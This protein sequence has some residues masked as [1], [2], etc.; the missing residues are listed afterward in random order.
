MS[1]RLPTALWVDAHL[2]AMTKNAT[3]FYFVQKGNQASGLVLLKINGLKGHVKLLAQERD[4]IEDTLKWVNALDDEIVDE[5]Q[6][7]QYIQRAIERDPDLWVLEIE[8]EALNNPF[9]D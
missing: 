9:T 2:A 5:K 3:P 7:D 1:E 8:D 6:A 4:F